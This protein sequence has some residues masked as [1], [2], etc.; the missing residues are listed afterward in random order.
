GADGQPGPWSPT[1]YF[2]PTRVVGQQIW[3]VLSATTIV[4]RELAL[5][6]VEI[7]LADFDDRRQAVLDSELT[8]VRDTRQGLRY[9]IVD[10]ETGERV[11]EEKLDNNRR[12]LVGGVFYDESQDFPIPL[13]G[14]NWLWFDWRGTGTQANIFFAGALASVAVSD[15]DFLGSR[16]DAG[17]DVFG[18]AFAGTD[19][20][21]RDGVEVPGEEVEVLSPSLDLKIGHPIGNFGKID[22]EYELE[23]NNYSRSDDTVGDFVLPSD[24]FNHGFTLAGRYNRRGY[25]LLASANYNLRDEWEP[26]GLPGDTEFDPDDDT[27]WR[28]RAAMG[29]TWHLPHFTKL[30]VEL[31]YVDGSQLDRFSK[32]QFGFFSDVR[33][34]GYQNDKVRA[35]RALASHLSYGFGV[36]E[37]FRIDLVGD[38][39]WATDEASGFE[40]EL[41]A[42]AG[43]AGTLVGPWRTVINLD[44]GVA[45]AGPDSGVSVFLAVLKLFN[46]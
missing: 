5:T 17:F 27:Y 29:K 25:R 24:H 3:S 2:L 8:M 33:V 19:I 10:K 28:W 39:A 45:L 6:D 40:E 16:F 37:M 18:L 36:G 32:Y 42:G 23:W 4:E 34:H 20:R 26:W 31:E 21:F 43:V 46:R 14:M 11:V 44:V 38:A 35:E 41:L 22:L 9:L 15:P 7:N 12:F 1:S 30:G 13:A